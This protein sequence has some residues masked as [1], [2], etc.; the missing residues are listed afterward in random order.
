VFYLTEDLVVSK[1]TSLEVA[2]SVK[3]IEQNERSLDINVEV[4]Y[5]GAH[6]K[7]SQKRDYAKKEL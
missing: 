2:M 4:N 6:V 5:E 7:S 3:R 1:G